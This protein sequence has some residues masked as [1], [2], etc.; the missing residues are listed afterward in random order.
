[1]VPQLRFGA[2]HQ[3]NGFPHLPRACL[4]QEAQRFDSSQL[5]EA[6]E[7]IQR[8]EESRAGQS[9]PSQIR[10]L[11]VHLPPSKRFLPH[12]HESEKECQE[13]PPQTQGDEEV[14]QRQC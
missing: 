4:C 9:R 13:G 5:Q 11:E 8:H 3:G 14:K 12:R 10:S 7:R 6:L 1:M 2:Q